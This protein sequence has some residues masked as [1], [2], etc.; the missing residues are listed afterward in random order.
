MVLEERLHDLIGLID[1]EVS[2]FFERFV[3][4][5]ANKACRKLIKKMLVEGPPTN[6]ILCN[7]CS[8]ECEFRNEFGKIR[9]K[10]AELAA[11]YIAFLAILSLINVK[12][13]IEWLMDEYGVTRG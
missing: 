13:K 10:E 2:Y 1:R 11:G 9:T 4:Y 7:D 5:S 8:E 6:M 12:R 3:E